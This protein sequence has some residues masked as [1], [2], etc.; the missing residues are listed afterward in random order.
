MLE[1]S[2]V[3]NEVSEENAVVENMPD[4]GEVFLH[5]EGPDDAERYVKHLGRLEDPAIY[6]LVYRLSDHY[7]DGL[8]QG[9]DIIV[10]RLDNEDNVVSCSTY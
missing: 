1:I 9:I 8:E 10:Y 6:S 2:V 5:Y 7:V 3:T 4:T